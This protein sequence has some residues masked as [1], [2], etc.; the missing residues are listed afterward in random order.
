M[1]TDGA[2]PPVWLGERGRSK[3]VSR[4]RG[5]R[6]QGIR[7]MDEALWHPTVERGG[8]D[9]VRGISGRRGSE[10][11][12]GHRIGSVGDKGLR[13]SI[14]SVSSRI[15]RSRLC[16]QSNP[17]LQWAPGSHTPGL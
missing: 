15:I 12:L 8:G 5:N 3:R 17:P 1:I 6:I 14:L 7:D 16:Q 9:P 10:R 13:L 2:G 11:L 4:A